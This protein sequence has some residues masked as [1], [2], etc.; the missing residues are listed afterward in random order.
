[1]CAFC[2]RKFSTRGERE[3]KYSDKDFAKVYF[4]RE[5]GRLRVCFFFRLFSDDEILAKIMFVVNAFNV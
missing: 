4:G 5:R 3:R 1:M 2:G